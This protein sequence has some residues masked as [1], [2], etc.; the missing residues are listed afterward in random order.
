MSI[1]FSGI[2]DRQIVEASE[3]VIVTESCRKSALT[4]GAV[5]E[6]VAG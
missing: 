2:I 3:P 1:A 5:S 6:N 4:A